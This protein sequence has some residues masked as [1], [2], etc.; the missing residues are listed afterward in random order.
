MG[1]LEGKIGI[2]V[3]I[4]QCASRFPKMFKCNFSRYAI[5]LTM[6]FVALLAIDCVRLLA[7]KEEAS[8]FK[9]GSQWGD[10][11]IERV[12]VG[13]GALAHRNK[14]NSEND[15][16]EHSVPTAGPTHHKISHNRCTKHTHSHSGSLYKFTLTKEKL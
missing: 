11:L 5:R 14:L 15:F 3:D 12:G 7:F 6:C 4:Y 10:V 8:D 2:I 16:L 9:G 13:G 1:F